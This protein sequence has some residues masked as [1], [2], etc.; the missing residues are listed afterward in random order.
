M[1]FDK[2]TAS[3]ILGT[4]LT[5][6]AIIAGAWIAHI[7]GHL[8]IKRIV[9]H[10]V[11]GHYFLNKGKKKLEKDVKKR[12]DTLI[13]IFDIIWR[14]IVFSTAILALFKLFFPNIDL[15]PLIASAGIIGV[16]LGFGAQTLIRDL[17]SGMFIITENQYRVG[18]IVEL[19]STANTAASG[20]VERI[21][22]RST[23][24]RD[25]NGNVHHLSNGN[26]LHVI[27]KT[28][29]YS[30]VYFT[31]SVQSETD[32]DH[33]M[34]VINQV[35]DQ[36]ANSTKWSKKIME[37]PHFLSLGSFNDIALEVNISGKTQPSEQW[38]VTSE[39]KKR[40]LKEFQKQGIELSQFNP[41]EVPP[42]G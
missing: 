23:V 25:I 2:T 36:L 11:R 15:T 8:L 35:G 3:W 17:L 42:K 39:M 4:G 41:M 27:N 13:S 7:I 31:I 33:L 18:D 5:A 1:M 28:M 30:N 20:A 12:Q 19:E 26:I 38:T 10:T 9:R 24:V 16:A 14:V 6:L 34:G 22:L 37:S 21:K 29:D 40:L 32:I